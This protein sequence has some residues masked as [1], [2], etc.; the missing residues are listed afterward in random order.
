MTSPAPLEVSPVTG[1]VLSA[2]MDSQGW[3]HDQAELARLRARRA[4]IKGIDPSVLTRMA[5]GERRC[6]LE[7]LRVIVGR[8]PHRARAALQ[9]LADEFGVG[10]AFV[11]APAQAGSVLKET[12][13]VNRASGELVNTT[14]AAL[15]D[16]S[17]TPGEAA[18]TL[19]KLDELAVQIAELRAA[20]AAKA[21]R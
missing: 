2:I 7:K 13:D 14:L 18:E 11:E 4:Q 15:E 21:S 3:D 20:V 16:G 19:A 6:D 5:Q 9:T 10:V 8:D 1:A 17:F 12:L